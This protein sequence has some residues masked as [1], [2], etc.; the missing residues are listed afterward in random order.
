MCVFPC[1]YVWAYV[2]LCTYPSVCPCVCVS[3][4][5]VSM[6]MYVCA[7]VYMCNTCYMYIFTWACACVHRNL[8]LISNAFLSCFSSN[9]CVFVFKTGSLTF[10]ELS[11]SSGL[12]ARAPQGLT[13]LHFPSA[14]VTNMCNHV[15]QFSFNPSLGVRLGL[16]CLQGMTLC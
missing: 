16:F 11:S 6:Y 15:W 13:C 1:V 5:C 10:L 8:R 14:E 12:L 9:V 4:L 2:C 3:C 7:C